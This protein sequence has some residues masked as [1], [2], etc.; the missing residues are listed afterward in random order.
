MYTT[1]ILC[2]LTTTKR[3]KQ[4]IVT[5]FFIVKFTKKEPLNF[6]CLVYK[7]VIKI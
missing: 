3:Q 4:N 2:H 5:S 6:A 7:T 1:V